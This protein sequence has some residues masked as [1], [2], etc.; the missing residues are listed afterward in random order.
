MP[1]REK[2]ETGDN[3]YSF[4]IITQQPTSESKEEEVSIQF[5]WID[6]GNSN[7]NSIPSTM[8]FCNNLMVVISF[9]Q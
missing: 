1:E 6:D 5:S 2:E 3:N 4:N 7:D 9:N 8:Y